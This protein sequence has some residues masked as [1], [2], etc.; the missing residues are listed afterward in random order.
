MGC[1]PCNLQGLRM[2]MGFPKTNP[3]SIFER[4]GIVLQGSKQHTNLLL[5]LSREHPSGTDPGSGSFL[6]KPRHV[7]L[8]SYV[9]YVYLPWFSGDEGACLHGD[10][11]A[12]NSGWQGDVLQGQNPTPQLSVEGVSQVSDRF[13]GVTFSVFLM[14]AMPPYWYFMT[15]NRTH[16]PRPR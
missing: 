11:N 16:R 1:S 2:D 8:T 7:N 6:R 3:G 15:V 5:S 12:G 4:N 9:H 13:H 10:F 14:A